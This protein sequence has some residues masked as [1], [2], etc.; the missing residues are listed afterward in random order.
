MQLFINTICTITV[1]TV[2]DSVLDDYKE[3][4]VTAR[5]ITTLPTL[6]PMAGLMGSPTST[7]T[8]APTVAPSTKPSIAPPSEPSVAPSV[9]PSIIVTPNPN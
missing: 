5:P 2:G 8:R 4:P 7:A 6:V 9:T 1:H 3:G